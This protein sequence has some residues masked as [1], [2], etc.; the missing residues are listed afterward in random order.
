MKHK[1]QTFA[2]RRIIATWD[3]LKTEG[4]FSHR[5]DCLPHCCGFDPEETLSTSKIASRVFA[6]IF[7][8]LLHQELPPLVD[9]AETSGFLSLPLIDSVAFGEDLCH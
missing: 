4:C 2:A 8:K 7:G 1:S 5:S 3:R 6:H 9:D